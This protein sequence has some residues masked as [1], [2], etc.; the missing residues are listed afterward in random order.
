WCAPNIFLCA[1]RLKSTI[2]MKTKFRNIS[3]LVVLLIAISHDIAKPL[4]PEERKQL[5]IEELGKSREF[6]VTLQI[7]PSETNPAITYWDSAHV[8]FYNTQIVNNKIML[9]LGGTG[10]VPKRVGPPFFQVALEHKYRVIQLSFISRPSGTAV[11]AA[12]TL[13]PTCYEDFRQARTYGNISLPTIPDQPHD[14]IIP[15]FV[16]LLQYLNTTDPQGGWGNY[17]DGDK[18]R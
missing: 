4:P 3:V 5:T 14:A 8:V 7:K 13:Y 10:G 11:C 18:P 9:W 16:K 6:D 12:L 2:T 1:E 17:L 15:R